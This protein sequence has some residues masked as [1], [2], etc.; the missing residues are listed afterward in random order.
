MGFCVC[1]EMTFCL[2]LPIPPAVW[3]DPNS[4]GIVKQPCWST[5]CP[6]EF[7]PTECTAVSQ[8]SGPGKVWLMAF[9]APLPP[10]IHTHTCTHTLE[11]VKEAYT[12]LHTQT[13]ARTTLACTHTQTSFRV[14]LSLLTVIMGSLGLTRTCRRVLVGQVLACSKDPVPK[15]NRSGVIYQIPSSR[16]HRPT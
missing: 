12:H 5:A 8:P 15:E 4:L 3:M 11:L 2:P 16:Y 1:V 13:H 6:A 10:P 9:I 7:G 14:F